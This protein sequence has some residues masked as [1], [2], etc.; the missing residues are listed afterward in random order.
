MKKKVF[1]LCMVCLFSLGMGIATAQ[2]AR[3]SGT[4]VDEENE[5][6]AGAS[7]LVKGT[8]LGSVTD[9]DGYFTILNVPGTAKTVVVSYVG[10][11]KV[12]AAIKPNMR[13]VL[14]ADSELLDEVMVVAYGTAKKSSYAGSASLVKSS[15]IKDLPVTT[16]ENALNGKVAGLTVTNSSGQ[17][18][19]APSIRIRGNGSMN[20]G[21]EPLYVV[22]GVPVSSGNAG[23]MS[24]YIYSTNN[25]MNALNPEN[26]E[27]ISVL[28]DAAASSLYGSRAANG[29]VLITTKKGKEG[30]TQVSLKASVGFT[31]SWATK[32][33]ERA[34]E[35]AQV[36]MIYMVYHD[37]YREGEGESIDEASRLALIALNKKWNQFG[38]QVR[39]EGTGLYENVIIED[40]DN[41]GRNG[42]F[43]DW[44]DALFRTAVYQTYD[45]AVSGGNQNTNYYSSL[46]YTKD[47]GRV[48]INSFDRISGRLNLTQK[49]G[50]FLEFD[51]KAD[52][53]HTNKKGY[54]D[55]R[56]QASNLFLQTRFALWGMYWP[57]NYKT[58]EPWTAT[59][60]SSARNAVY[61]NNEMENS[62]INNRLAASETLTLHLLPGLD[63]KSVF[64]YDNTSVKD[65]IY[66]S[67]NH[68]NAQSVKGSV[69]D[70]ST[71]SQKIVSSTTAD[72]AKQFGL[73]NVGALLGFEA[74]KNTTEFLRATGT[75][76]PSSSLH[77]VAT[78]GTLSANGYNWGSA[79]V[80]F[81]SKAD[82]N[83]AER[84]FASA[85]YRRDGSS[86][87]HPDKRWGDFWSVAGAWKLTEEA[88]LKDRPVIS[89][90]KLRA[91][92]GVNGTLPSNNY[93]YMNLMS[94]T[95]KYLGN[96][97]STISTKA[98]ES[99][100][101]ETSYT[102]NFGLDFGL[103][104]HKLRG[105]IE[106]FNRDS[107]NLLQD[108]PIST[109]TGFG[110]ILQNIGSINNKGI[111]V[112]LG[113]AIIRNEDLTW[114]ASLN[115]TFLKSKVTKLYGGADIIY[116][117][118]QAGWSGNRAQFIYKEGESTVAFWG[119]EWAGVYH[120][121]TGKLV[122]PDGS[123]TDNGKNV[124]YVN[125]PDDSTKGDF[126]YNGR[127]ATFNADD[128]NE[129]VIGSAIPKVSGGIST[130]VS[131]KGIDLGLNFIYKIGGKLYDA[132]Y[133]D[134]ADDGYYWNTIR[135]QSYYENMWSEKNPN[136]TLPR[137][138]GMDW[139]DP[140][141]FSTRQI[142][143][144]SLLR[145]KNL[146]MGYT[147][148]KTFTSKAL[149]SNARVFFN[150]TNLLT[151]STFKEADPE[152]DQY[153]L[154]TWTTP[155][156]KTFMFGIEL[157]F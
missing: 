39:T 150:A 56:S 111:E 139:W 3:V 92:Y 98:N 91:S 40:Y 36:N 41:S 61:Y 7:V 69:N 55:Y 77:T 99:L 22:D 106:Y 105:T 66:Y 133:A 68:W 21:N 27:S 24:D 9:I 2:T 148:P 90:L 141:E 142:H 96:P 156:G 124:Y 119:K 134:V 65:H 67:A 151:F 103:F 154:S 32:N 110:S 18:G 118:P 84:Y 157:K 48:K 132:A 20:A 102:S 120:D 82:Y 109:I 100:S 122:N 140:R 129:M 149:I 85:S 112:E 17:A 23:Q 64:A 86:K 53:S 83:W 19:S 70:I 146:S 116:Y 153:G 31:P 81:L 30:K 49:V 46:S 44:E 126:I 38:Y 74:E 58:G 25:V 47:E 12:E 16:F 59:Y 71:I 54:G 73:H 155:I 63:L 50:K 125:D 14:K 1:L 34:D 147:L 62:A 108:V 51:T 123:N 42:Q 80:S 95:N 10:Y 28:K 29:V 43:F 37:Y 79:M 35:Q 107:K 135:A 5:P 26:I 113:G 114:N 93:G 104:E 60:G 115:A 128:A 4:V 87:L 11:A 97:G 89:D 143:D 137:I 130:S 121:G 138:S 78:A 52:F 144:A 72:Y 8:S 75:G 57:T 6:V 117:D 152:V 131:Y 127:G 15:Q 145:L 94:Y 136:G 33:Y 45:L 76:L 101:W 13:V 88:F